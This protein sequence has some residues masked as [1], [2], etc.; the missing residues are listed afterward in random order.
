M[1]DNPYQSP[2]SP[3]APVTG[4]KSGR[5]EDLRKVAVYQKGI[6]ICI[7]VY[8][9][10]AI[11][12]FLVPPELRPFGALPV[13]AGALGGLVFVVLLSI[14]VY[15]PV[16][17]VLLGLLMFVPCVGLIVLLTVNGKATTIL[18]ENGHRVG[19]LGARLSEF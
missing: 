3:M 13:L 7:L 1:S 12:Q 15:S 4:V 6:M 9:L 2:M 18:R 17:G 14:Q 8:L 11:G 19:L 16:V 10:G 5:R